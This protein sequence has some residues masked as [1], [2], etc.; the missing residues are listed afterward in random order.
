MKKIGSLILLATF[1]LV[2]C[3]TLCQAKRDTLKVCMGAQPLQNLNPAFTT[4]RHILVLYHNWGDTLLY[5]DPVQKR[6]VPCLSESWQWIDANTLEFRL[7]K[8]VRFHNGEPFGAQAVR[9]S[10]ELLKRPDS[11]VSPYLT[12]FEGV[13]VVD[14]YTVRIR[15]STPHPT[16]PE[17]IANVF[18]IYPPDY[19]KRVGREGFD[20]HPIGTGP[21]RFVSSTNS[22]EVLFTANPDYFG[23]PKGEAGIPH[24][25][26]VTATEEMLEMEALISGRAD[27]LRSTD[28]RQRQVPFVKQ[29]PDLKIKT[30]PILRVC[31]LVMDAAGRSGAPFFKDKRVR[32]AVNHAIHREWIIQHA[33]NGYAERID[34]VTSPLHFGHE[35]DVVR[36]PYDPVRARKLLAEAGYPN[37]FDV[38]L[39]AA[40]YESSVEAIVRDLAAVGITVRHHWMGGKWNDFYRKFLQGEMP[41]AFMTWGSYSIFDAAAILNPFFIKD[42]QGCYGTTPELSAMLEEAQRTADPKRR[43]ELLSKAQKIIAAEAL[44]APLGTTHAI[45][46][47]KKDLNFQPS[48]D[49]IDRYFGASWE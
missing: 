12:G 27:L 7:R 47:M 20:V 48:Y 2:W 13:D 26:G 21:Y 18:F 43:R 4:N 39:F 32:M 6:L 45:S 23:G 11:L 29:N 35:P 28:V 49:E 36:Y 22:S 40:V 16:A 42:A 8:G 41:L 38:D 34:S 19:Y 17:I 14:E 44:W 31:F 15:T 3:P 37:G 9:F 5:R 33:F 1:A 25:K 46:L 10:L 30:V 24:L